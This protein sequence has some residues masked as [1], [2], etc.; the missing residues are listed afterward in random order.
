MKIRMKVDISGTRNGEPWPAQ[1]EIIDLPDD[2]AQS[3]ID[4]NM[5]EAVA[6]TKAETAA[7]EPAE[8]TAV[9]KRTTRARK[10]AP[11]AS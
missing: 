1:G 10:T 5:A 2:E 11:D 6:K 4:N 7:V 8:E 3:L 9:V